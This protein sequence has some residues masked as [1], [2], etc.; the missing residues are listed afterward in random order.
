MMLEMNFKHR[1]AIH[2]RPLD[3]RRLGSLRRTN[4]V[5]GGQISNDEVQIHARLGFRRTS[6]LTHAELRMFECKLERRPGVASSRLVRQRLH[7]LALRGYMR[8][9]AGA[10]SSLHAHNSPVS[11]PIS[12]F[13]CSLVKTNPNSPTQLAGFVGAR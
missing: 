5:L 1:P 10:Y 6:R 8:S 12:A 3:G 13:V 7:G 11:K 2:S 4:T 9:K